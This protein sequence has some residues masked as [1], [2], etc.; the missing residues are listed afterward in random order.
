MLTEAESPFDE[1]LIS[2]RDVAAH[3]GMSHSGFVKMIHRG[4]GPPYFRF[5]RMMRFS[6]RAVEAWAAGRVEI[7]A[8]AE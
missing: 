3:L 7:V 8:I 6:P 4:E 2:R 1:V 5:G